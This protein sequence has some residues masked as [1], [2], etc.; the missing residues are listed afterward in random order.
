MVAAT[1]KVVSTG[2]KIPTVAPVGKI[3]VWKTADGKYHETIET[4]RQ[5]VTKQTLEEFA[6]LNGLTTA[7]QL[8]LAMAENLPRITLAVDTALKN[9]A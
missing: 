2:L 9:I 4:V 1:L 5:T 7:Q 3:A 6:N 8:A